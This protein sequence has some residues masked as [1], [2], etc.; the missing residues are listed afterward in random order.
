MSVQAKFKLMK[1]EK[2]TQSRQVTNLP[3]T[4]RPSKVM[5]LFIHFGLYV[6]LHLLSRS[7]LL[8]IHRK[9]KSET[10]F[11]VI[12]AL[13]STPAIASNLDLSIPVIRDLWVYA[14]LVLM[15]VPAAEMGFVLVPLRELDVEVPVMVGNTS[16]VCVAPEDGSDSE[17]PVVGVG[18]GVDVGVDVN[19]FEDVNEDEGAKGG[20]GANDETVLEGRGWFWSSSVLVFGPKVSKKLRELEVAPNVGV[21]NIGGVGVGGEVDYTIGI[22]VGERR[23]YQYYFCDNEKITVN[24]SESERELSEQVPWIFLHCSSLE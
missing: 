20:S 13:M 6:P 8:D 15:V 5:Q 17:D 22:G 18:I 16:E 4:L 21:I 12:S 24:G 10:P 9:M 14:A 11:K 2:K 1:A 19:E 7:Y 23:S 3:F